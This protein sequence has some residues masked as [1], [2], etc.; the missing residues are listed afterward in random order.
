MSR[1]GLQLLRVLTLSLVAT[2]LTTIHITPASAA[3]NVGTITG[4]YQSSTGGG[5]LVSPQCP[6]SG[7]LTGIAGQS[8]NYE[9]TGTYKATLTQLTASCATLSADGASIS[10]VTSAAL[11][12]YGSSSGTALTDA[13]C[14]TSGGTQ[15]IV[16]ARLYKTSTSSFAGG[17]TLLCGTLPV[18]GSRTYGASLGSTSGTYEDIACATGSVAVGL[19]VNYGGIVD[20]F[21]I[22]CAPIVNIPQ[23]ITFNTIGNA[24]KTWNTTSITVSASSGLA[25]T[26]TSTTASICTVSG[27]TVTLVAAGT[28]SIT[29]SQA[30]DTNFVA[31]TSVTRT[32]QVLAA[33]PAIT[34]SN[35]DGDGPGVGWP[36]HVSN[37]GGE[38]VTV[39]GTNLATCTQLVAA[40]GGW[41][42]PL[43]LTNVSDTNFTFVVPASSTFFGW[44][45]ANC[46]GTNFDFSAAVQRFAVPANTV[47]PVISGTLK[48]GQILS[49]TNGTWTGSPTSYTYQWSRSQTSNGT[50]TSIAGADTSTYTLTFSD[51]TYF[52][53]ITV[54]ARTLGTSASAASLVSSQVLLTAQS[55]TLSS[56]GT[57][58]KSYPYSQALSMTTTGT[59]GT[60]A[61]SFSIASGGTATSCALSDTSSVATLTAA[62]SGTCLIRATIAFDSTYD[63]ATST[64]VTFMFNRASQSAL[65]ISS[66]SGNYGSG[67]TLTS[68]GGT[69]S[70]SVS[71]AYS[72]GT[73]TCTLSGTTLTAA[74]PGT[75][76]VT[77]TKVLDVNYLAISSSQTT[78]TFDYGVSTASVTINAG[79]LIYRQSKSISAVGNVAGKMTFRANNAVIAGC[80]NLTVNAGNSFTRSCSFKPSNRGFVTIKVTLVPTDTSFAT[81]TSQLEK[82]FIYSRTGARA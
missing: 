74:A 76:L 34:T 53:K 39:T 55:I 48:P 31:A 46:G 29:A 61:I 60:G 11:G 54:T 63:S 22:S 6:S 41:T 79:N 45:R 35:Y 47:L 30:G 73:T 51:N 62:T 14:A 43:D 32:F 12:T 37:A 15:V 44:I 82:L 66:T 42:G 69:N 33:Y 20:K 67:L 26:R 18:G 17:V 28:C 10:S 4:N 64:S 3:L 36:I 57:S 75:C 2:F 40:G 8:S 65:S 21:G 27:S 7:V 38:T 50:F 71:Y 56:L 49:A 25:V 78:I 23:S 59:S 16:G 5:G 24:P 1:V 80:K 13:N 70:S 58:S 52:I 81:I 68:T 77:A 19:Y 9:T 72:P